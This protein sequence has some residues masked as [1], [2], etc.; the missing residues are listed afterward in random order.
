M[1]IMNDLIEIEFQAGINECFLILIEII[2]LICKSAGVYSI[3]VGIEYRIDQ[4]IDELADFLRFIRE[5]THNYRRNGHKTNRNNSISILFLLC[6][7]LMFKDN[8]KSAEVEAIPNDVRSNP[9][10]S[11]T[12]FDISQRIRRLSLKSGQKSVDSS[13]N[14]TDDTASISTLANY[15]TATENMNQSIWKN[16][17]EIA[18]LDYPLKHFYPQM[19]DLLFY[20]LKVI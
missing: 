8:G 9:N 14:A 11:N 2:E 17:L 18:L 6:Q 5:M 7:L 3:E 15:V 10:E 12:D 13:S 16:E 1:K 20:T 4:I 19:N